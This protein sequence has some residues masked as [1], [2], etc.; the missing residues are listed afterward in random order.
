[1]ANSRPESIVY[2]IITTTH[3]GLSVFEGPVQDGS[4]V[5]DEAVFCLATGGL[6]PQ[7]FFGQ[8]PQQLKSKS[9]QVR[10]RSSKNQYNFGRQIA[11]D[12]WDTLKNAQ[13][14]GWMIIRMINSDTIYLG[15]DL[16]GRHE[17]SLNLLANIVE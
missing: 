13:P 11:Q 3:A 17:W 8:D 14:A 10:I 12:V 1:M 15:Q 5:T 7:S 4:G 6:A 2:D 9:V 16:E